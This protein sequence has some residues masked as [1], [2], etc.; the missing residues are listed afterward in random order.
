MN[1]K[2]KF[3]VQPTFISLQKI[4]SPFFFVILWFK[5]MIYYKCNACSDSAG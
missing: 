4:N 5:K 2:D 3:Y 1:G